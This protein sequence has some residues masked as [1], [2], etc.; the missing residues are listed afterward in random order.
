MP[1]LDI[2]EAKLV[3]GVA[4]YKRKGVFI[5]PWQEQTPVKNKLAFNFHTMT[6]SQVLYY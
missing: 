1:C 4:G 5:E 6:H 2:N 3:F